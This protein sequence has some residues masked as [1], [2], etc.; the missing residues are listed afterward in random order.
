MDDKKY[1]I[2]EA[3]KIAGVSASLLYQLCNDRE[4]PHWRIGGKGRRG[5][6]LLSL[7]DLESFMASCRVRAGPKESEPPPLKYIRL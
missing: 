6:I 5:K 7:A 3:A 4:I 2:A 1:T